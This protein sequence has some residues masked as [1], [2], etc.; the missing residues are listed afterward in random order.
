MVVSP[1]MVLVIVAGFGCLIKTF[2]ALLLTKT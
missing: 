2:I 1:G